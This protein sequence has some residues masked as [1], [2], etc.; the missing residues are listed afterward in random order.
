MLTVDNIKR[1]EQKLGYKV[2]DTYETAVVGA[3]MCTVK[4]QILPV[5]HA[6]NVL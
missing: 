5:I 3:L 6:Q 4:M 2:L 1:Q